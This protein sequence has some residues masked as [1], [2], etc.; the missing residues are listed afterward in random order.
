MSQRYSASKHRMNLNESA[1]KCSE[2]SHHAS[3]AKNSKFEPAISEAF[4]QEQENERLE[5]S[6]RQ[7]KSVILP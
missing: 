1:A 5:N 3:P 4:D 2:H 7:Y 6:I